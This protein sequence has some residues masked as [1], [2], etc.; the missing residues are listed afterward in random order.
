MNETKR[1]YEGMFVLPAGIGDFET[2]AEPIRRIMARNEAEILALN[3][4][5][6]RR[7]AYEIQGYRRGVYALVYF[8]A[9]TSKI[10]EIEHD[11]QLEEHV[12]RLLIIRRDNLTQETIEAATPATALQRKAEA[13]EREKAQAQAEQAAAESSETEKTSE[14][15][16]AETTN[17][18]AE[19]AAAE[20]GETEKASENSPAETTSENAEQAPAET[21]E[22]EKT[23]ENSPA[24]TT[25]EN[26][27]QPSEENDP[28]KTVPEGGSAEA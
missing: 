12:L 8:K 26:T 7:L 17:E 28:P 11:C 13:R 3:P 10:R 15:G 25:S 22:T 1:T 20:T 5:D 27:E 4:W 2:V 14:N 6:E 9:E 21:G 16:P 24:E 18:N 23:S 19:Q